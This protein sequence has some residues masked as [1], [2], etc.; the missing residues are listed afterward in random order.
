MN[1]ILKVLDLD[2]SIVVLAQNTIRKLILEF[3]A[4]SFGN[5]G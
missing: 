1:G 5:T 2:S 4:K 3:S